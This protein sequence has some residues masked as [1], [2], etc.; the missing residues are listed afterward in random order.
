MQKIRNILERIGLDGA[1]FYTVLGRVIQGGGGLISIFFITNYLSKIE[2]GY[3]YTF[4][5]LVAIQVF[6]E[7]GF[8][9]IVTQYVAHEFAYLRIGKDF[10]IEG[11]LQYKSRLSSLFRFCVKWYVIISL[12]L[13]C[14]LLIIGN[15]F[16]SKY[17][18]E[19]TVQ[20]SFPWMLLA[21]ATSINL[22]FSP[23]LSFM[24]GINL[25]KYV[26]QIRL[27]QKSVQLFIL[28]ALLMMGCKLY[29][30]AISLMI[31]SLIFPF[32]FFLSK[33]KNI[34]LALWKERGEWSVSYK[35]EIFPLQ[36]KIALSW[37]S[38]YFVYQLFNPVV[39][40]TS[41]AVV[42][43]QMGVT[44]A[45]LGGVST[46]FMS[47]MNTK[48]PMFSSF[49]AKRE[50]KM[51]DIAFKKNLIQTLVATLVG[52]LMVVIAVT[53][54]RYFKISYANRFL[55][56]ELF[57]LLSIA[58]FFNQ[59]V[60]SLAL[61]LRCHKKEPLL[62]YSIVLGIL[63]GGG[64][65]FFGNKYGVDGVVISYTFFVVVIGFPWVYNVFKTKK[66]EW[67]K[68]KI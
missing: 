4:S 18:G 27:I 10:K 7:L 37:I 26:A 9:G 61:Y 1:V 14:L 16:F 28:F 58:T 65:L 62:I 3:F 6:F 25:I 29:S 49:I 50:Y 22:F 68:I 55:S 56:M 53:F 36:W 34:F 20:W 42:A 41:G 38:G 66:A 44:I 40:A 11:D 45:V 54:L 47:W 21:L 5:S 39:F 51:L 67:H 52:L 43:G 23:L 46:I 19:S 2:Q 32:L 57:V 15:V 12:L 24:E 30:V 48:V 64:T 13:F 60:S 33:N 63:T 8:T 59:V 31:S 17:G 35:R